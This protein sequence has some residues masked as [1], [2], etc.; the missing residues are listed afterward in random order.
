MLGTSTGYFGYLMTKTLSWFISFS[1]APCARSMM[2]LT[3]PLSP[4]IRS[5]SNESA[6]LRNEFDDPEFAS[7][8]REI[9]NAIDRGVQPQ[10]ISQGSS[11]SYFAKNR[12][13]VRNM[14]HGNALCYHMGVEYCSRA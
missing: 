10:R 13:G 4:L 12:K 11:G 2:T 7:L 9:K 14:K 6:V 1:H 5:S 3:F 8:V